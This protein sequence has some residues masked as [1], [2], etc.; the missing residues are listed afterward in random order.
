MKGIEV[1]D[2]GD[3]HANDGVGL[4]DT[5]GCAGGTD[6][7][8]FDAMEDEAMGVG[9]GEICLIGTLMIS[10]MYT[11]IPSSMSSPSLALPLLHP[12]VLH[13]RLLG[14]F[15][16]LMRRRTRT[17]E[18]PRHHDPV[19]VP[20]AAL[21]STASMEIPQEAPDQGLED[22]DCI[23]LS[24]QPQ[25]EQEQPK[26][27]PELPP[28]QQD[29]EFMVQRNDEEGQRPSEDLAMVFFEW[30]KSNKESISPKT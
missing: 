14:R 18:P 12:L 23:N 20:P 10:S 16:N 24:Q 3:L 6:T 2:G 9:D 17:E 11:T 8:G 4:G 28:Q 27:Q 21:S 29:E 5:G 30:L 7:T 26:P 1:D 15:S 25:Q 19:E 22:V 13:R